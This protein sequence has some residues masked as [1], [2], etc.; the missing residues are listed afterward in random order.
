MQVIQR[1]KWGRALV[2]EEQG[3]QYRRKEGGISNTED[4]L[5]ATGIIIYTYIILHVTNMYRHHLN[6]VML[7]D[8]ILSPRA[9][10]S[11]LI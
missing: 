11:N 6:E 2:R 1:E 4:V 10:L 8:T 3:R 7:P 5:K 9:I